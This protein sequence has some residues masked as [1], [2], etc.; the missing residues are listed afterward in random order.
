MHQ[1]YYYYPY[2]FAVDSCGVNIYLV[3]SN[4]A[5]KNYQGHERGRELN[6]VKLFH[7]VRK[8]WHVIF[9]ESNM[10]LRCVKAFL[11][12]YLLDIFCTSQQGTASLYFL[13]HSF[14]PGDEVKGHNKNGKKKVRVFET[15]HL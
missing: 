14:A 10:S 9:A 5:K 8:I 15:A 12:F 2:S 6:T 11:D 1:Q 4:D 13:S 3:E 7:F